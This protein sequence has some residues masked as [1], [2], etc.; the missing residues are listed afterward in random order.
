MGWKDRLDVMR[1]M[2]VADSLFRDSTGTT[3]Q[4][5][6]GISM[7]A[8]T[9]MCISGENTPSYVKCFVEDCGYTSV[10]DE[11]HYEIGVMYGLPDFPLMYTTSMLCKLRYGWTF[12][13]A[14]AL[15]QVKKCHKPMLFIHGDKDDFVPTSMIY[16][17]YAAKP[18]PKEL[19]IAKGSAH[20]RSYYDHK[21]EYTSR[22]T[23]FVSRYIR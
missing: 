15:K 18:Q 16:P 5:V 7:G 20:A 11:F 19:Y 12:G 14:S 23:K 6:H 2:A 13:E 1:W 21:A 8:A 9:T 3:R 22:V 4:I 10:W 17:L